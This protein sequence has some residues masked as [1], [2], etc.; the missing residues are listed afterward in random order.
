MAPLRRRLLRERYEHF[1][2]VKCYLD[3]H[4]SEA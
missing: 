2:N 1:G 4:T 3:D